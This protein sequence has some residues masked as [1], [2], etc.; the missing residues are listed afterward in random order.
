MVK[1]LGGGLL[2]TVIFMYNHCILQ[3]DE[4]KSCKNLFFYVLTK[5]LYFIGQLHI[6][7]C[8]FSKQKHY[9]R[10]N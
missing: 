8:D 2:I 5:I 9:L 3:A 4:V 6:A 1:G 10:S 7:T